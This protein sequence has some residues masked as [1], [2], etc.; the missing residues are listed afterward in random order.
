MISIVIPTKNEENNILPLF[1]EIK[2]FLKKDFEIILADSNSQDKTKET[3]LLVSKKLKIKFRYFNTK[4]KDLSNSAVYGF[5]KARGKYIVLMD[6]DL[7]HPPSLILKMLKEI[8]KNNA[9]VIIASR[10]LKKSKIKFSWHR[11]FIARLFRLF[12]SFFIP[13][14][15]IKDPA[16]GFFLFKSKIIKKVK[17]KPKGFRTLI[18]L[19]LKTKTRKV[20][21]IPFIFQDRKKDK[22]K[23]G[24][25]Q[26]ITDFSYLLKCW[27][28]EKEHIKFIKFAIVGLSGVIVNQ[29]LLWVLTEFGNLYYLFSG[30]IA[31]EISILSNFVLNDIWSFRK[32]R[33][34]SFLK[35]MCRFNIARILTLI[36]NF[37]ILWIFTLFGLSYLIS[38]L[39]GIAIATLLAYF[40]SIQ[41]VWKS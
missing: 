11:R 16:T 32:Q 37:I 23:L 18:E 33:R 41:W 34:G 26:A 5:K 19:L 36:V 15:K 9:D 31:I 21:E 8:K 27:K 3:A 12:I 28:S 29:G 14:I 35:R 25:K 1:K 30:L 39:I 7:Q 40:L 24:I 20:I 38:N 13:K 22:S 6:A 2:K 17:L 10:F 4:N